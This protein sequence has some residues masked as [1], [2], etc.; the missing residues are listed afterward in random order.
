MDHLKPCVLCHCLFDEN[1]LVPLGIL[2]EDIHASIRN[3]CAVCSPESYICRSD[4][5]QYTPLL[6]ETPTN[7]DCHVFADA[8]DIETVCTFS[9]RCSDILAASVGSWSFLLLS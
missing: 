2:H 5:A 9:D 1:I 8:G 4:L 6:G 3:N 7:G